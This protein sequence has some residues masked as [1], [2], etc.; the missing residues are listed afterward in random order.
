MVIDI[1]EAPETSIS[2]EGHRS[3]HH[4]SEH[5]P[6]GCE[7]VPEL[8]QPLSHRFNRGYDCD[9]VLHSLYPCLEGRGCLFVKFFKPILHLV[10]DGIVSVNSKIQEDIEQEIRRGSGR[11]GREAPC[12][13]PRVYSM[14]QFRFGRVDG[15]DPVLLEEHEE[16]DCLAL[17]ILHDWYMNDCEDTLTIV[18]QLRPLILMDDIFHRVFIESKPLLQISQLPLRRTLS[19][20]PEQL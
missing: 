18:L 9:D 2:D 10:K 11:E 17:P 15:Y 16:F 14:D 5:V 12:P 7:R 8:H 3:T 13:N 6:R 20:N 1:P 4:H 19:I